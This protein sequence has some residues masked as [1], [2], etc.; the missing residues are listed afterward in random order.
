MEFKL[1]GPLELYRDGRSIGLT[2]HKPRSLLALLLLAAD[3]NVSFRR[4]FGELWDGEPPRSAMA[5]LRTYAAR[6]RHLVFP[7]E[8]DRIV[9]DPGGYRLRLEDDVLDI[10]EFDRWCA[11][12]KQAAAGGSPGD[13]LKAYERARALWR[14]APLAGI[15]RGPALAA[16][17][18]GLEERY[19][20]I[21]ENWFQLRLELAPNRD[22]Y[23]ELVTEL[24]QQ[25]AE[26]PLRELLWR[27]LVL[28]LYR[29]G[30]I[31]G[32]LEACTRAR[33]AFRDGLGMD[34]SAELRRLH[35]SVL[36]REPAL[37]SR[38]SHP[39]N[40][41]QVRPP[42]AARRPIQ[43]TVCG[44][45]PCSEADRKLAAEVGRLVANRGA[46]VV[47]SAGELGGE[48]VAA[49]RAEGGLA[50]LVAGEIVSCTDAAIGLGESRTAVARA[51]RAKQNPEAPVVLVGAQA[52]VPGTRVAGSPA[53]AV[54][55]IFGD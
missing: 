28:A 19:A 39:R 2:A 5:N 31:A 51:T 53:E 16:A 22:E 12:G 18:A 29:I 26:Y 33:S 37:D 15:H 42:V 38:L 9:T 13:A 47:C 45:D 23:G 17:A 54:R 10:S 20:T 8:N 35:Q 52:A 4:M 49:A 55:Y 50:V 44:P 25:V 46:V 7:G 24:R 11:L 14:G 43:V 27:Q 34:P 30:D 41:A 1:L 48:A 36:R 3:R 40:G 21:T 32:A 6:L